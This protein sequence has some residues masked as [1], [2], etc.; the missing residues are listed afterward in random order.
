MIDNI[1]TRDRAVPWLAGTAALL[2]LGALATGC[3][4]SG[5]GSSPTG[6]SGSGGGSHTGSLSVTITAPTGVTPLVTVAG[7]NDY[8]KT[9][10]TTQT[11]ASLAPG[12]Y[13]I[14]APTAMGPNA[15][16][17]IPYG[18]SVTGS[19]VSVAASATAS[20]TVT[21]TQQ[22]SEG[23]LLVGTGTRVSGFAATSLAASGSPTATTTISGHDIS[24]IAVDPSGGIWAS[25][26]GGDT[27]FHFTQAQ[28]LAGGTPTPTVEIRTTGGYSS[29]LS[30]VAMDV[31]GDLW[32]LDR[33]LN[34]IYEYTPDQLTTSGAPTPAATITT[35]LGSLNAPWSLAFDPT[36]DLWVADQND[37][38]L[39]EL[40]PAALAKG[41]SPLPAG[42]IMLPSGAPLSIAFDA[43][44]NLWEGGVHGTIAKYTPQMLAT[45]GSPTPAVLITV[46]TSTL[47]AALAFDASGDLWV[48]E[49]AGG[50]LLMYTPLQLQTSGAPTPTTKLSNNGNSLGLP[51]S[52]A[53]SP[54]ASSLPLH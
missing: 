23:L 26:L 27:L 25:Y 24:E 29:D 48:A 28:V 32:V 12:S 7:P 22:A 42:G 13:T 2:M 14:I 35:A 19:P 36:G 31:K 8:V 33:V 49:E 6:P 16:V 53:F 3:G 34:E 11:L 1:S 41:G 44:G 51:T 10:A 45:V 37:S 46:G 43:A 17:G 54:H 15:I 9:I 21:Y 52:L 30:Q 20:A 47:P 4:T 18:G 40:S 39:V 38:A 5:H 50:R